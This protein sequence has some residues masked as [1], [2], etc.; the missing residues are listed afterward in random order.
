MINP[1]PRYP[2]FEYIRLDSVEQSVQFLKD[3]WNEAIPFL[4]GTDAFIGL[5]NRKLSPKYLVDLK[6]LAGFNE[7]TFD[8][9]KGLTVGA[10]VTLNQLIASQDVQT[11][12]QVLAQA[13]RQVGGYQVRNRATLVGNLCNASPCGDTIGP[14][15]VYEGNAKIISPGSW[16]NVP[17]NKFFLGPGMTTLQPGE[18]VESISYPVPPDL[19]QGTYLCIGRNK[20]ADLALAAVTI[21]GYL[22]KNVASGFRFRIALSAV[23]PTV[24]FVHEAQSLLSEQEIDP[25]NFEK[26]AQIAKGSCQPIDDIRASKEYRREM[27]YTLTLRGL[28]Q[29]WDALQA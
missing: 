24:I 27:V 4:G 10:G 22:D 16:R 2:E 26:A 28:M 29:V 17:L 5:R 3:H 21:V 20:L 7:L 13:A 23:A 6:H 9:E 25:L 14:S 8:L 1:H 12:Y 19:Y 18:I 15:L 11:S